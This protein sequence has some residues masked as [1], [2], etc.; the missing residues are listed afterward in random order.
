MSES[1]AESYDE[2]TA[3]R[4]FRLKSIINTITIA[5]VL[6]TAIAADAAGRTMASY[7]TASAIIAVAL[8]AGS[9][10][11]YRTDRRY[12]KIEVPYTAYLGRFMTYLVF[13][14]ILWAFLYLI[15]ESGLHLFLILLFVNGFLSFFV[16][17]TLFNPSLRVWRRRSAEI[18]D[19]SI[20]EK[21]ETIARELGVNISG[22]RVVDWSRIR[23]ANAFQTGVKD[24]HIFISNFLYDNLTPGENIAVIAHEIGHA[25][26]KHVKK[27]LI[28]TE[29][30]LIAFTNFL[31]VV[32]LTPMD[33]AFRLLL[34][35]A[36]FVFM[37]TFLY[38][39]L[40]RLRK[41]YEMEADLTSARLTDPDD[42][43]S[44]LKKISELNLT[45]GDDSKFRNLSHPGLKERIEYLSGA[46]SGKQLHNNRDTSGK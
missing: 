17:M 1:G 29:T 14:L 41:R 30:F 31:L 4:Y 10:A 37:Y 5:I 11:D 39:Y 8:A 46:K 32:S 42:L 3:I 13:A 9:Y 2:E 44:A 27:I 6:I 24:F 15:F 45:P 34:L 26:R 33:P 18:P 43:I 19:K 35:V 38:Q 36:S 28:M 12:R 25:S 20:T 16:A 22:I 23:I 21:A 40:P 7:A